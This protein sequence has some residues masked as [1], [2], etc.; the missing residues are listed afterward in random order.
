MINKIKL[1]NFKC[2]EK[3][4]FQL[5]KL[6]ILT[7]MNG[8][9]KSTV[10]QSLLFI[11]Q[12]YESDDLFSE[13]KTT[14]LN[15]K[16]VSFG[17][18]KDVRYQYAR[19]KQILIGLEI[20]EKGSI[21]ITWCYENDSDILKNES[22]QTSI[23]KESLKSINI[24]SKNFYYLSAERIGPRV[25]YDVRKS[26]VEDNNQLGIYG[27]LV[28]YYLFVHQGKQIS[29]GALAHKDFPENKSLLYQVQAWMNKIRPNIQI[30]PG[31]DPNT[32]RS[33]LKYKFPNK[34]DFGN[35]FLSTNVGF[36]ITFVLSIVVAIL[37]SEPGSI[38]LIENPEA[39]LHPAGQS[40]IAELIS[41]AAANGIQIICETHSDHIINGVMVQNKKFYKEGKGLDYKNTIIYFFDQ[42][43]GNSHVIQIPIGEG[44]RIKKAPK[45]FFDQMG[46]DLR[47][48]MRT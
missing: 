40:Q 21:E 31:Y 8:M 6:T 30:I 23:D 44:G 5:D 12:S 36:G 37:T 25:L 16:Y 41:L 48:L 28:S 47:Y 45:N 9:G 35:E 39:H 10:I 26:E 4:E 27:E 24:F 38:L 46:N 22:F 20:Q 3:Q 19:D 33:T 42:E 29:I 18:T 7:G 43:D 1:K 32:N 34:T 11:R 17:K 2:F 13:A 14:K 15:G